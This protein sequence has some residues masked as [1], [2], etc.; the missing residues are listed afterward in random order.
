MNGK[1]FCIL[2]NFKCH[3]AHKQIWLGR[4]FIFPVNCSELAHKEVW[5]FL[6]QSMK[7][8]KIRTFV[9]HHFRY[10]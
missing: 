6:V 4:V 2:A 3:L 9:N 1:R 8:N 5:W 10:L 7:V